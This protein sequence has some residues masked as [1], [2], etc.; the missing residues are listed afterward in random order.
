MDEYAFMWSC[1]NDHK[2]VA[3]CLYNK[4]NGNGKIN[5]NVCLHNILR[6]RP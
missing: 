3:E 4:T 2:D 1:I 5:I 6:W